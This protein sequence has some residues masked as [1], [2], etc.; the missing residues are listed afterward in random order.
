MNHHHQIDNS[1]MLPSISNLLISSPPSTQQQQNQKQKQKQLEPPKLNLY[2][3]SPTLS[4]T[5]TATAKSLNN[6]YYLSLENRRY[7]SCSSSN[8][9]ITS[10]ISPVLS[11][12]ASPSITYTLSSS[13]SLSATNN[14]HLPPLQGDDPPQ[15][16]RLPSPS[17]SPISPK[18]LFSATASWNTTQNVYS[19]S[20]SSVCSST[21]TEE[22]EEEVAEDNVSSG[23]SSGSPSFSFSSLSVSTQHQQQQ[24]Q[25]AQQQPF[26]RPT[27][28]N[29]ATAANTAAAIPNTQIVFDSS[30]Q[31][32]LKRRRGRPP[33]CLDEN[34]GS[35]TFLTP[36][37]WDIHVSEEQKQKELKADQKL[38]AAQEKQRN[39][40]L[41]EEENMLNAFTNSNMDTI[42]QMPKKKRGRK[43]KTHISGNS[44]FV[45]KDLT[46]TRSPSAA[47]RK[48]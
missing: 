37:V 35:F 20:P 43:P 32:I 17:L 19:S 42:L 40:V 38:I 25:Q 48:N 29:T 30:G 9:S 27:S 4:P 24:P 3:A 44:C 26:S 7:S 10:T 39:A 2:P 8:S 11:P 22:E 33:T 31:P 34:G 47:V 12:M 15:R 14:H 16:L 21:T 41:P 45:W 18:S 13:T 1:R 23:G 46:S 5:T 36:T 28:T 6:E